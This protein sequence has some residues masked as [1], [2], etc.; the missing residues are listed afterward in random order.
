MFLTGVFPPPRYLPFKIAR[1]STNVSLFDDLFVAKPYMYVT[2][3]QPGGLEAGKVYQF[4]VVAVYLDAET[5][6]E[7][8][9]WSSTVSFD[10]I[11][12]EP[13]L[14]RVARRLPDGIVH[15]KW[16]RP[17]RNDDFKITRFIILFR[18]E[19]R[20]PGGETAFHGFQHITV[21][22]NLEEY[23][24]TGLD[25]D[26]GYQFVIYGEHIPEGVDPATSLF[27]GG[28]NG[29]KITAFSQE[30]FVPMDAKAAAAQESKNS[31]SASSDNNNKL[32]LLDMNT[33]ASNSLM[34]LILGVL[35]GAML[36]VMVFLVAICFVRQRKEK[37]RLLAQVNTGDKV[38]HTASGTIHKESNGG[39]V[40]KVGSSVS[41]SISGG[42]PKIPS[43]IGS[44]GFL[45][46]ELTPIAVA[47]FRTAPPPDSCT[48]QPPSSQPI[49]NN[50]GDSVGLGLLGEHDPLLLTTSPPETH[51][52]S[53]NNGSN[54]GGT[55]SS[56][57]FEFDTAA[58]ADMKREPPSGGSIHGDESDGEDSGAGDR[59]Q[60]TSM[61]PS[62]TREAVLF[63]T[64]ISPFS[65]YPLAL[66]DFHHNN[67][68]PPSPALGSGLSRFGRARAHGRG[69][70]HDQTSLLGR[71]APSHSFAY[72]PDSLATDWLLRRRNSAGLGRFSPPP[73]RIQAIVP[74][75][76]GKIS[77]EIVE[78]MEF[79]GKYRSS[80]ESSPAHRTKTPTY[81]I[82][83]ERMLS[84]RRRVSL[85]SRRN[86]FFQPLGLT[87]Q[88][89][90][91][92]QTTVSSDDARSYNAI[93]GT[94][95]SKRRKLS[96]S[97]SSLKRKS[98]VD[99]VDSHESSALKSSSESIRMGDL[100]QQV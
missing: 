94:P 53:P 29:R 63:T 28:L 67:R 52:H 22:G 15:I 42:G 30:V 6:E 88:A 13:P 34:F 89:D 10:Y 68:R 21:R 55:S 38:G 1:N 18:K 50:A 33:N 25:R 64:Q 12:P 56:I 59:A 83:S 70:G 49:N 80:N 61:I 39:V 82:S 40:S 46:A 87:E 47:N 24:V 79:V 7:K 77:E 5:S 90:A 95:R 3:K 84:P 85:L 8:S 9:R 43:V 32:A 81:G 4:Q 20:L 17:W 58:V 14:F 48:Q 60:H 76:D 72:Y 74:Q 66:R 57:P 69:Y 100:N 27:T 75:M 26:A 19:K 44:G 35:A 23:K 91:Y 78:G 71:L 54:S 92:T 62:P 31:A 41:E 16:S 51:Y 37:L 99:F 2:N 97:P 45:L 96:S 65:Y 73:Q 11:S 93:S 98:H 36:I 86:I